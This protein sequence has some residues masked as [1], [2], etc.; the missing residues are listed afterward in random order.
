MITFDDGTHSI[1]LSNPVLGDSEQLDIKVKYEFSMSKEIHSTIKTLTHSKFLL[2]F[3][4]LT[5][6]QKDAFATFL[7]NQRGLGVTYTDYTGNDYT[8]MIVGDTF[9]FTQVSIKNVMHDHEAS[10]DCEELWSIALEF[11]AINS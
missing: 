10:V 11:E 7:V 8:G 9:D 2:T 3:D 4:S 5:T 1:T 6:T